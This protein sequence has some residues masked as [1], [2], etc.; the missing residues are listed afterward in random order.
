MLSYS[1]FWCNH[2]WYPRKDVVPKACPHCHSEYWYTIM[3]PLPKKRVWT[4]EARFL[5]GAKLRGRPFSKE[6]LQHLKEAANRPERKEQMR[7]F[8]K[9]FKVAESTKLK[10]HFL[11][12]GNTNNLGKHQPLSQRIAVSKALTGITRGE[13]TRA[14]VSDSGKAN[15]IHSGKNNPAWKGGTSFVPYCPKFNKAFKESVRS[16]FGCSC[17]LCGKHQN[18]SPRKL[19]V[20]HVNYDKMTCCNNSKPMFVPLCRGCH[21]KVM[22]NEKYYETLFVELINSKYGGESFTRR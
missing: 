17:A 16:F 1:C 19:D 2:T 9:N 15:G 7:E 18:D 13:K 6:H 10:I 20:H 21:S 5:H 4:A 22:H 14:Y 12:M 3:I 11:K 8:K